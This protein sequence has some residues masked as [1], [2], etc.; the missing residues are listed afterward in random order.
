[1]QDRTHTLTPIDPRLGWRVLALVYDF[2]PALA[3]W[4][5]VAV[6]FTA[7]HGDSIRGGWLGLVEF[8]CL[9]AL[10]G[11]YATA[12]W[13]RGG[14]TIGMKPWHLYVDAADCG[15]A[16]LRHLWLRYLVGSVSLLCAGAGFWW[17]LF[18]RDKL[19][20]HDRISGTRLIRDPARDGARGA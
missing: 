4:F 13:R 17:A 18:D 15:R 12:S 2:F 1:M 11:L 8:A 10:T 14:Q 16:S 5:V 3:L 6:T 9:Y 7:L 19:T 20:W